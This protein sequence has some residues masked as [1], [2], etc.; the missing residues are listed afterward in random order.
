MSF[1]GIDL[2]SP[3]SCGKNHECVTKNI[4]I[5]EDVTAQLIEFIKGEFGDGAKG[6]I[7]CDDNTHR[8]SEK[9]I[10]AV[11]GGGLCEV[12]KL[13]INSSHADE[14]MIEDCEKILDGKPIDYIIAAGSGTIHDLTR[15]VA[16]RK[17]VPFISYPTASSVDGF[18]SAVVSVTKKN[19]MK[20]VLY[21]I[22]P[23]ALFA[24][25]DVLAAAPKRLT[26]SGAGDILGK[27]IALADWRISNLLTGEYICKPIMEIV[28][29]AADKAKDSLVEYDK[30]KSG[31]NY[32]KLCTDLLDALVISGLCMQYNGNSRPASG[33][34]HHVAHFFEMGMILKTDCLHGEN[35]G[36]GSVLCAELYHKFANSKNIKFIENQDIDHDMIKDC[37]KELYEEIVKE[38]TPN[39]VAN[40]TAEIFY[41]N[42]DE[43]KNII[44]EIPTKEELA[45]LLDILGGIKDVDGIGA[46]DLKCERSEI[47]RLAFKFA[48][49]V[50]NAL[51][52]LKLMRCV[53]TGE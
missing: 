4:S 44:S 23:I 3:C 13:D 19:G 40:V 34:E 31:E 6:Y 12:V 36:V 11:T 38:N 10:D 32:K 41:N 37:Y 46:Y 35:V 48:P 8:A 5:G 2:K 7:I 28:Y 50:R 1:S 16:Y 14:F 43:I 33:A 39:T 42:L 25:T 15:A 47:E 49:Y 30:N 9:M 51:T 24:D 21:A 22:A 45:E 52:L 18:V 17:S 29:Y 26:A 53:E 20:T 27:Y